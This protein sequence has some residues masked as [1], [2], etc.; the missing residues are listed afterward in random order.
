MKSSSVITDNVWAALTLVSLQRRLKRNASHPEH[1]KLSKEVSEL[2]ENYKH[3]E[4]LLCDYF[5]LVKKI[6]AMDNAGVNRLNGV[7]EP[8]VFL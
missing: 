8:A 2:V 3:N 7:A 6:D 1:E 4:N 5:E